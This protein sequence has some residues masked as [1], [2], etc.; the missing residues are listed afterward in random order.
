[1]LGAEDDAVPVVD[2][3]GR[4]VGLATLRHHAELAAGVAIPEQVGS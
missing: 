4:P 2:K 3:G 1:M